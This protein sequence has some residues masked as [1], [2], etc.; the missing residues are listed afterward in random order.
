MD[1]TA[2]LIYLLAALQAESNPSIAADY[3]LQQ[4][5]VVRGSIQKKEI[6]LVFTGDEFGEGLGT[7]RETLQKEKVPA[8]FYFTGRFYRNDS[9]TNDI[10]RLYHDGHL[11][12]P[13]SDQHI[14]YCDW[15]KRDST[16]VSR[17]S[18]LQDLKNNLTAMRALG[19]PDDGFSG[20]YI[21]PYEWWNR[22]VAG[23][24]AEEGIRLFSCTAGLG[25]PA[26]YT[27]PEMGAAYK[28]NDQILQILNKASNEQQ[29]GLNGSILLI[30]AGADTR[31]KEKL[32]TQLK[33]II[34]KYSQQGYRFVRIDQ[35]IK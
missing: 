15:K 13:H 16:L 14:L 29:N 34:K 9:F 5:A 20:L 1:G 17:D 21:P 33:S 22:E 32:F 27:Y 31:R 3:T 7:I 6:A 26:D 18:L 10:K 4:G 19:I 23:W 12:G 35:L 28:S 8:A 25:T 2:S 30:H 11:L 24:L